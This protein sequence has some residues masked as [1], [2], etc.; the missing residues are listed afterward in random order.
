LKSSFKITLPQIYA[1]FKLTDGI[2]IIGQITWTFLLIQVINN[3]HPYIKMS[4]KCFYADITSLSSM[5][6]IV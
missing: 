4:L 2:F 3:Y 6:K 5:I 1:V